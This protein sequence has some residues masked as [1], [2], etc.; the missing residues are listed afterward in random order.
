MH[1]IALDLLILLGGVWLVAVTLRPLGLPTIMGE[2]IVGVVLGPAV[3][4]LIE[5]GE[6]IQL[7]AEIGIFFLMFHAGVETQP[8][9]FFQALKRSLGVAIVGA[10]V[11]FSVSFGIALLFGL[12]MIGA[13]FVG[14]TMTATAVVITLKSLKDLGLA[15]TRVARIIIASCV[16]DDLLTLVFFGLVIGVLSGGEFEPLTIFITLGKV[17]GFA[18]VAVLLGRF[19]YPL[20]SLPFRS[21]GG[22]G[23]TFVL[24]MAFALGLFAEA[25]GLHI[26]LGAYVAGLFFEEKVAHPNLVR[27]VKDRAYGIAYSFLGPIFFIS[28]GFSITFDISASS[29]GFIII[30]TLAVIIGQILSAGG[31]ALRMGLPTREA[32]TVGVGMC[33]RAEI[34]F[35]LASLALA[36]G[37]IDQSAFSALIF[38]AFLLNLFTPLALKG[39]AV[40]LEGKAMPQAD[41]T[42]GVIQIDKFESPLVEDLQ[43]EGKLLHTLSNLEDTVVIYGYGPEVVSLIEKL[44]NAD[45]PTLIIEE[46]EA[47]AR[48]LHARG[49][50]VVHASIAEGDLNLRPI[51]KARALV[52][53]GDDEYNASLALNARELGFSGPIV[54]L[55]DNP[56]RRAPLQLAGA[57][58]AFTPTHVLAAAVAVRVSARIGPRILGTQMLG[59][60]LE[61]VEIRVHQQSIL[62]NKTLDESHLHADTGVHI[63]GL[64]LRGMLH[65]PPAGDQPLKPGMIL[66]AAGNPAS[67]ERL[68]SIV[69]PIKVDHKIIVAG[70]SDVG[71]KLVE[72]LSDAGEDLCVIDNRDAP[73]VNLIGDILDSK[74]LDQANLSEARVVVLA[75]ENDSATLLAAKVVRDFA[76]DVPIVACAALE[77]NVKRIQQGGADFAL[78]IS[79]VAEQLLAHHILGEMVSQQA[80]IKLVKR[81]VS[82]L[83]GLQAHDAAAVIDNQCRIIAVGRDGDITLD[84]PLEFVLNEG[85][86]IYLCG[87]AESLK[88]FDK[89]M[90]V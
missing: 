23:F 18:V 75:C 83:A 76:P 51:S 70:Y 85:D 29:I 41:A 58:A 77:E 15:N 50:H 26:I 43:Y 86:D 52:T 5:P 59:E 9:E 17:I 67:I 42:S 90:E 80:H 79:Q 37:A 30:L 21:E 49:I 33:G 1:E 57:T 4:G 12:D 7:L 66:V 39:C 22:K 46:D 81:T 8:V 47:V 64:W 78:S 11:P 87:T 19:V 13:T 40:M 45:I 10:I 71:S 20:L 31:M 6:L 35:I 63:V 34:A 82:S 61:V 36:Q 69:R 16:I 44:D 53:N 32:L 84:F 27:I 68:S 56:N 25:I 28:L 62:A 2:L 65:T 88:Q 73:R 3:L 54:A 38:T 74:I 72:M 60:S 24:V 89:A 14:L 55:I 48:R